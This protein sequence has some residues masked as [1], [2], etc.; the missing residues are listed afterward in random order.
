MTVRREHI[1]VNILRVHGLIEFVVLLTSSF[2]IR[3]S[4]A[5]HIIVTKV[6]LM[7]IMIVIRGRALRLKLRLLWVVRR[8]R[9][10]QWLGA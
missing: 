4:T 8:S 10:L 2:V 5:T 9:I 1:I 3:H 7:D 6:V